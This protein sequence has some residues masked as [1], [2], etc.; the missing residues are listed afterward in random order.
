MARKMA[1]LV[2]M[3]GSWLAAGGNAQ[4]QPVDPYGSAAPDAKAAPGAPSAKTPPPAAPVAAAAGTADAEQSREQARQARASAAQ[5][6]TLAT[7]LRSA[8]ANVELAA[9]ALDAAK[10][11][12]QRTARQTEL[13]R[14]QQAL[15]SCYDPLF[16]GEQFATERCEDGLFEGNAATGRRCGARAGGKLRGRAGFG[17]IRVTHASVHGVP[18]AVS[19]GAALRDRIAAL[20]QC[21]DQAILRRG[22]VQG[23]MDIGLVLPAAENRAVPFGVAMRNP[24]VGD[25]PMRRCIAGALMATPFPTS[26]AGALVDLRL[27]LAT[28]GGPSG[29]MPLA[30]R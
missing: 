16:E 28:E 2:A 14:A 12:A 4:A 5:S 25:Q 3:V 13:E 6:R 24:S 10:Q 7:C 18:D 11:P 1:W 9:R 22:P 20:Q 15:R 30:R 17:Q 19:I 8:S 26:P 21:H 23:E 29:P 27:M